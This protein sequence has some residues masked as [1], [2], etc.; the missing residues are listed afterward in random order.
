MSVRLRSLPAWIG[1][2]ATWL[3]VY[4][5]VCTTGQR[6]DT[7]YL[8]YGWQLVPW[9]VLSQDPW[10]SLWYLHVQP[11]LWNATLG[12]SAWLSPVSDAATL[13]IVMA[14]F[15]LIVAIASAELAQRLGA[16]KRTATI[17]GVV[18][19]LHPEVLKGA[20]EPTYELAVAALLVV[21]AAVVAGR[22]HGSQAVRR[23]VLMV[24]ALVTVIA[25]TRSLYHPLWAA[26]VLATVLWV[27]RR[28]IDRRLV[29]GAI[30]IPV[31]TIGAWM[32]KNE[33]LYGRATLSSWF[34]MNL[35]RAVIP[36]LDLDE[37]QEM[38]ERGEVSDVAMIG[39]FGKYSLYAPVV[40]SCEPEHRHRSVLEPMRKTDP[41]SPNFNYEC[42]LPVFDQAGRDA[43][44]VIKEHP[45]VWLEGRMWSLRTTMAV[46][47]TPEESPSIV[48]RGLD[49]VY[50]VLRIDYSGVLS[51]SGWGT[52][53][54]GQ[55]EAPVD[56]GLMLL[57]VYGLVLVT[58]AFQAR[59]LF[60][61]G[62]PSS[63]VASPDRDP[64]RDQVDR[65]ALTF[66]V[67][68]STVAFTILVGAV[69]EL[70]EQARFRTMTDP[71]AMVGAAALVESYLRARRG[72]S[73]VG[74]QADAVGR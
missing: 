51:T 36:V 48:M 54:F 67:I 20:F 52:P 64:T 73:A 21:L 16:R 46:A 42:F 15:G 57:P 29:I 50:S 40:E 60:R 43:W 33:I 18:A 14:V 3:V 1:S 55:L 63:D 9:D 32:G 62:D 5:T 28:R 69:A 59:R 38:Y 2:A 27:H 13:Q 12:I 47:I 66:F 53:I 34:G 61:R 68:G 7:R 11:P 39:P 6:F 49:R 58:G 30:L 65:R 23:Q 17:V 70:G 4:A 45:G 31:I 56:F 26:A 35:Q 10:R 8:D 72:Q 44:A 71:L 74:A 22:D 24:S 19:S 25:M 41:W 37:L